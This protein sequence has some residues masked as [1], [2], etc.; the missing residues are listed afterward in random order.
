MSHM[1][2]L[3]VGLAHVNYD[4]VEAVDTQYYEEMQ[5]VCMDVHNVLVDWFV[6]ALITLCEKST[7]FDDQARTLPSWKGAYV[8]TPSR[9]EGKLP[10]I[11]G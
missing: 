4:A 2:F 1:L 3:E 11:E 9:V 8:A 6:T 5:F 7:N 10:A